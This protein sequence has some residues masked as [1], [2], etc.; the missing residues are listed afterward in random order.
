[1]RHFKSKDKVDL[2]L[3]FYNPIKWPDKLKSKLEI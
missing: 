1:M 3:K 2:I